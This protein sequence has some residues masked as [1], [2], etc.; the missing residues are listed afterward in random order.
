MKIIDEFKWGEKVYP[1]EYED[2]DDFS[3]LP[4]GK[5]T[6]VR[7]ICFCDGKLLIGFG[8]SQKHWSYIGGTLEKGESVED[9]LHR[10]VKEESNHEVL[11]WRPIGYQKTVDANGNEIY[12]VR[13]WCRVKPIGDFTGDPDKAIEKIELIEPADYKK[14]VNWGR[15]GDR[16]MERAMEIEKS[17]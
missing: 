5:I 2:C 3:E 17:R 14:Y 7:A 4:Q 10:E 1:V 12:Q 9:A 6:Q 15:V 13:V 8:G 11:A 16:L